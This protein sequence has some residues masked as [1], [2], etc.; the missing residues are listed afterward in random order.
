MQYAFCQK[1]KNQLIIYFCNCYL[2]DDCFFFSFATELSK[3]QKTFA[4][5]L[6]EFNFECIDQQT[7][8]EI[9]IGKFKKKLSVPLY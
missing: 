6:R 1:K 5:D 4:K 9:T 2:R 3:A 7:D 8:D